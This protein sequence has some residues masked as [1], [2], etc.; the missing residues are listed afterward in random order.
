MNMQYPV[1]APPRHLVAKKPREW[2]AQEAQAY[3]RW[4]MDA[5][6]DRVR[7]LT[8]FLGEPKALEPADLARIGKNVARVLRG[9]DYCYFL[10]ATP[11]LTSRGYAIA[12]DTGL[13]V[14][15]LLM[16]KCWA[17]IKWT[18]HTGGSNDASANLPVVSGFK[19]DLVLEPINTSITGAIGVLDGSVG[20]DIWSR[21][22]AFWEQKAKEA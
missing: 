16:A 17:K 19:D 9:E 13:L 20:T 11:K 21:M 10:G 3:F 8:R 7:F 12:A 14:T 2:A 22:F 5:K 15:D 1:F 18:I 6:T 4:L